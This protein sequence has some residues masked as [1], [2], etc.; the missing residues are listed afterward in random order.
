MPAASMNLNLNL[1]PGEEAEAA[2][3]TLG[4]ATQEQWA[5]VVAFAVAV[6]ALQ[7][8]VAAGV[9]YYFRPR[10]PGDPE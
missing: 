7:E 9:E 3:Q 4:L 5:Q 8:Q 6:V 2:R 10:R 1:R